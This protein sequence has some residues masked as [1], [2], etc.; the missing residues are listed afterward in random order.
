VSRA[1]YAGL[2]RVAGLWTGDTPSTWPALRQT[3]P[4]LLNLG[5]SGVPYVGSDVGGYSG[6]ATPEL[7]ARWLQVGV[8]SPFFRAH[9]TNGVPG[10]EPWQ[11]G[12]EVTDIA[13]FWLEE[14]T[15]LV[16]HFEALAL[17]AS[18]TGAPPLRPLAWGFPAEAALRGVEDT[19]L[20][21]ETLLVAPVLTEG[22]TTQ[23]VTLPPGRWVEYF[24]GAVYAGGGVLEQSV[25][26]AAL[27]MY[28]GEGALL[29]RA[30]TT[31]THSDALPAAL[32][33]DVVPGRRTTTLRFTAAG[34]VDAADTEHTFGLEQR[35]DGTTLQV[36]LSAGARVVPPPVAIAVRLVDAA[37][38]A[39]ADL[40]WNG[41]ALP[42]EAVRTDLNDRT[43][44]VTL[45]PGEVGTLEVDLVD[46]LAPAPA[47]DDLVDI[48]VVVEV[49]E[50]TPGDQPIHIAGTFND[51]VQ[52]PLAWLEPGRRAGGRVRVPR[53]QWYEYKFTRGDWDTVEKWPDCAE[54]S[55]RYAFGA[56]TQARADR[57]WTWRDACP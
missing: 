48:G 6:N 33:V 53:G 47:P 50:G 57:I 26:L 16:P 34:L 54:A 24:S 20:L 4:M 29:L 37:P 51:W 30:A 21:G 18:L 28:L 13:R 46:P 55:N 27:P 23:R 43:L 19:A 38:A 52:T 3:L 9:V 42:A 44:H 2:Q 5:A 1:G 11:F 35:F 40:R 49:P 25:R 41:A 32:R 7:Y 12:I 10:Q 36:A 56:A 39:P 17:E 8:L 14:R 45:P 15:R 31:A 22:E